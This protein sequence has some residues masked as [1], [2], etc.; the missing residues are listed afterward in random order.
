[1]RACVTRL[2]CGLLVRR[3]SLRKPERP[4]YV[5]RQPA[6]NIWTTL[7][8]AAKS[9][10]PLDPSPHA[11]KSGSPIHLNRQRTSINRQLYPKQLHL[12]D[13]LL[14]TI[15]PYL[16][17]FECVASL[18]CLYL[19]RFPSPPRLSSYIWTVY[20]RLY[21]SGYLLVRLPK[22]DGF[23]VG[24]DSWRKHDHLDRVPHFDISLTSVLCGDIL[25]S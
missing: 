6:S 18:V 12:L 2:S 3:V 25:C 22:S 21:Q 13:H 15:S 16:S 7:P 17:P 1:V 11:N 14:C 10:Y 9:L 5:Y 20:D 8:P 23:P 19:H 4:N 24:C